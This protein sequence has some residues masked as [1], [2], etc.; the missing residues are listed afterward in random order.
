MNFLTEHLKARIRHNLTWYDVLACI[1]I[2]VAGGIV[3]VLIF[4]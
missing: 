2:M 3:I 1:G 4:W